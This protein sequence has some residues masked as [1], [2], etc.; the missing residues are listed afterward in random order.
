MRLP[1][2]FIERARA[3]AVGQRFGSGRLIHEHLT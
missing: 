1:D 2:K 3:D